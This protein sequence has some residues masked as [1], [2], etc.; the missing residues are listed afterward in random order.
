[1]A[2]DWNN[3]TNSIYNGLSGVNW[4]GTNSPSAWSSSVSRA[5]NAASNFGNNKSNLTGFGNYIGL[6]LQA[7]N[8]GSGIFNAINAA[9]QLDLQQS[10]Y[11][12]A[13]GLA[14]INLENQRQMVNQHWLNAKNVYA[15]M[16]G[17]LNSDG[18]IGNTDQARVNAA[19]ANTKQLES[20]SI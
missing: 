12:T 15:G 20:R 10:M 11:N 1:M 4:S 2:L 17:T 9:R 7:V 14:N 19:L 18:S 13:R 6:G 5:A 3:T 16:L 8:A